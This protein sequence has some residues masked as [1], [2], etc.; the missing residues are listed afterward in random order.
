MIIFNSYV[1]NYQ[2]VTSPFYGYN[3]YN[4]PTIVHP[5]FNHT[6]IAFNPCTSHNAIVAIVY[7]MHMD[8]YFYD[9]YIGYYIPYIAMALVRCLPI[10]HGWDA[11][12]IRC[13]AASSASSAWL[14]PYVEHVMPAV[15][16]MFI[17]IYIYVYMLCNIM[18]IYELYHIIIIYNYIY[19]YHVV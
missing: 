15:V 7:N 10:S 8:F 1:T 3:W 13:V 18:W 14:L 5:T 6:H 9:I 4:H 16:D 19:I 17:Y 12:N 2:R 11:F